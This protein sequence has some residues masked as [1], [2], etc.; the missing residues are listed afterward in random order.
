MFKNIVSVL[1][2]HAFIYAK[3]YKNINK[4]NCN[5][6]IKVYVSVCDKIQLTKGDK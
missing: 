1:H 4:F 2:M 5:N 6:K 3:N